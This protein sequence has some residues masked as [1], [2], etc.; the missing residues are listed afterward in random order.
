MI[1]KNKETKITSTSYNCDN[2]NYNYRQFKQN[3]FG[4]ILRNCWIKWFNKTKKQRIKILKKILLV[5]H[6]LI[7]REGF[8]RFHNV[9]S[10]RVSRMMELLKFK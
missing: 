3:S 5:L 7:R 4:V 9:A 8:G 6:F 10:P 1:K 2:E